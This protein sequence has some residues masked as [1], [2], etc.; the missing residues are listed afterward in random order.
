VVSLGFQAYVL[1]CAPLGFSCLVRLVS[2]VLPIKIHHEGVKR[3]W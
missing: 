3:T 1:M 2:E